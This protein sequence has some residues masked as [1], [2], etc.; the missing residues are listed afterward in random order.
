MGE[1]NQ[2]L[3]VEDL[4]REEKLKELQV[5]IMDK[6]NDMKEGI[7]KEMLEDSHLSIRRAEDG[8]GNFELWIEEIG[9]IPGLQGKIP[10]TKLATISD[11]EIM[12][13]PE[14]IKQYEEFYK[15]YDIEDKIPNEYED[16]KTLAKLKEREGANQEKTP[17]EKAQEREQ[18]EEQTVKEDVEQEPEEDQ[19]EDENEQERAPEITEPGDDWIR[20]D[21][22]MQVDAVETV[23]G[24]VEKKAGPV[25]D[26]YIAPNPKDVHDYRLMV[27]RPGKNTYEAIP[28]SNS[29]GT[30]PTTNITTFSEN[31]VETTVS[32]QMLELN[33]NRMIAVDYNGI[34]STN[35]LMV[36]R[37]RDNNF[38][39]HEIAGRYK[40]I[41][42]N[43][44]SLEMRQE[45][46]GDTPAAK[47]NTDEMQRNINAIK[48]LPTQNVPD[49]VD[50]SKDDDGIAM[51]EIRNE[52]DFRSIIIKNIKE[53]LKNDGYSDEKADA[54]AE[55]IAERLF[56]G[57]NREYKDIKNDVLSKN[58]REPGGRGPWDDAGP[59]N[60]R[61]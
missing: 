33:G 32:V 50:P 22:N 3:G 28:L 41:N 4:S 15:V 25:A 45:A 8:S 19:K 21:E 54:K 55:E 30:N 56:D 53:D 27:K 52:E 9:D 13:I 58:E 59:W 37:T 43:K 34:T 49:D 24:E 60:R 2:V 16:I 31:G 23:K 7:S 12:Y 40:P 5:R 26:M 1:D 36:N 47:I 39:G 11:N 10:E 18:E 35:I 42:M 51:Y 57:K 6:V 20:I 14:N 17:E 38:I 48:D 44:P 29:K 61:G 46:L